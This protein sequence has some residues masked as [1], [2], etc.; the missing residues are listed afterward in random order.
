MY[1]NVTSLEPRTTKLSLQNYL[2]SNQNCKL[3]YSNFRTA[4][5]PSDVQGKN[6]CVKMT[7]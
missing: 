6:V 1:R 5:R 2:K 4:W 7:I 3:A